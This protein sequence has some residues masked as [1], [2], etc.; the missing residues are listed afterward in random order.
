MK[1][2]KDIEPFR[3][4]IEAVQRLLAKFD[5]RGVIIGGIAVGFLG[6]PRLTEDV[7]AMFLLSAQDIPKFLEAAKNENIEPRIP[8]ADEFA[9]KNRVLLLQHSPTETNIDISLGIMP[10]E[11]EMVER[12]VIQSTAT[13][14]VR[15]PSPEDLIVMKAVAHRLKDLEDIQTIVDKNPKLDISRI[16]KWV[17]QFAEVLEMPSLWDDIESILK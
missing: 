4:T 5:N 10:F 16:E 1:L 3:A 8:N 17:K 12:G 11:E 9:R 6:R 13:L 2:H 14:S 15:L 7:D